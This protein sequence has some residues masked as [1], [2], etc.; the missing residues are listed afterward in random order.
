MR[1]EAMTD[2]LMKVTHLPVFGVGF[3]ALRIAIGLEFFWAGVSKFGG[4]SAAG[5][6]QSADGPLANFFHSLA[7]SGVVDALNMWGLLLIGAALILGLLVRPASIFG[8]L[9]MALYYLAHFTG[10]T[11]NGYI[12]THIIQ[13][14]A[15]LMF[16]AGGA[17]HI[18]GLNGLVANMMR[19]PCKVA[20]FLLG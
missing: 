9:L 7:G 4:W 18:F 17:G 1:T 16:S 13:I 20:K 11:A 8:M 5:Y 15:L 2:R 3:V 14:A 19:K 12:E 6:L 10:N